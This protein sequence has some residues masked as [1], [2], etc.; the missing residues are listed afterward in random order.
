MW[1]FK[2]KLEGKTA[3]FRLP[4]TVTGSEVGSAP[5][6]GTLKELVVVYVLDVVEKMKR[7]RSARTSDATDEP[8][9]TSEGEATVTLSNER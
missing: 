4:Q 9:D 6:D 3:H 8:M 5:V 2:D 1:L 7:R